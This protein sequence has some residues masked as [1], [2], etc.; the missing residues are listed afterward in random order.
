MDWPGNS[1]VAPLFIGARS[2]W[3]PAPHIRLLS[4]T[5][6]DASGAWPAANLAIYIP[7]AIPFPFVLRR[8]WWVNGSAAGS[9]WVAGIYSASGTKLGDTGSVGGSGN[10]TIQFAAPTLG[11]ISLAAGAYY[12]SI[13][14]SVTTTN[15]AMGSTVPTV[16]TLRL[17]GVLQEA[18]GAT[19]A[20]AA[21]TGVAAANAWLPQVGMTSTASGF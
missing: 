6:T 7:F 9:N 14:H 13:L 12:W 10:T 3:S 16:A 19:S 2:R 18:V 20:P 17:C 1:G 21:M 15:H 5:I 4:S 8:F 11:D